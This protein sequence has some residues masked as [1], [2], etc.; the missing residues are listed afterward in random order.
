MFSLSIIIGKG[1]YWVKRK[2]KM[3]RTNSSNAEVRVNF[4]FSL[5]QDL[6][7]QALGVRGLP[8]TVPAMDTETSQAT[9]EKD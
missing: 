9:I 8:G 7:W 5:H 2:K 3:V 4:F 1:Q 6:I